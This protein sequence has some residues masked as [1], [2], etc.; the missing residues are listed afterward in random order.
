MADEIKDL[1]D[2]TD[3]NFKD[4]K[5]PRLQQLSRRLQ[6]LV[7]KMP[8]VNAEVNSGRSLS[9]HMLLPKH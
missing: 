7:G 4:A 9:N 5:V 1:I 6:A 3:F 8:E 2:G